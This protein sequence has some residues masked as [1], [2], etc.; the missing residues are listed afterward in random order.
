[1]SKRLIKPAITGFAVLVLIATA[2]IVLSS[3]E[4]KEILLLLER[5]DIVR[6][7]LSI[8]LLQ[9]IYLLLRNLRWTLLIR[10][11]NLNARFWNLYWANAAFIS[12]SIYTPAQF[13]EALKIEVL[14][15]NGLLNAWAGTG[16]FL[17]ERLMD[18]SAVL[19]M[20]IVGLIVHGNPFETSGG[21]FGTTLL[22]IIFFLAIGITGVWYVRAKNVENNWLSKIAKGASAPINWPASILITLLSCRVRLG[23]IPKF[24]AAKMWFV[25]GNHF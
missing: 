2:S 6:Y 5:V 19:L 21:Q 20:G 3:F 18:L 10:S 14:R 13:G 16:S 24:L 22:T 25:E 8:V 7:V 17:A 15:R 23:D 9:M 11:Q 4:W 12:I 1:M